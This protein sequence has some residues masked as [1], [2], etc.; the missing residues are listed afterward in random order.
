MS[1]L[2]SSLLLI[3]LL[4]LSG[5]PTPKP[6]QPA[7][8]KPV[9]PAPKPPVRL[10][11]QPASP[12]DYSYAYWLHSWRKNKGEEFP[13][14]LCLETDTY[15]MKLNVD[16]ITKP[17][18]GVIKDK[19]SNLRSALGS[20][21]SRL[22]GLP[23]AELTLEVEHS[24][25][26]YKLESCK[27]A[28]SDASNRLQPVR[29]W[30]AGTI[31][32]HFDIQGLILKNSKGQE[33]RGNNVLD[34]VVWPNSL[35][36]N[37]QIQPA[38]NNEHGVT[39]GVVGSGFAIEKEP[40]VI[41]HSNKPAPKQFTVEMWTKLPEALSDKPYGWLLCNKRHESEDGNF[42]FT[43]HHNHFRASMNIGGGQ[44][45]G[46]RHIKSNGYL[47][48]DK[49]H[50]LVLTYD[51]KTMTFYLDGQA[52][53]TEVINLPRNAGTE[54][55]TLGKRG[56]KAGNLCKALYDQIRMWNRPLNGNEIKS[57]HKN[58]SS[59]APANGLIL[60]HDFGD[61]Y[62]DPVWKNSIIRLGI[63]T[64]ERNWQ[65][66]KVLPDD[67]KVGETQSI[68]LTENFDTPEVE[69]PSLSLS[70]K[71]PKG[72]EIPLVYTPS[73][74]AYSATVL[75]ASQVRSK[76]KG[77]EFRDYDDFN[78]TV[79]NKSAEMVR[80]PVYLDLRGIRAIT[81]LTPILCYEDGTPTGIPV[82]LSKNWHYSKLG[83]Y[84][85]PFFI[86]PS[87]PNSSTQYKLRVVY[88]FYGKLPAASHAQLSL[89][90]YANNTRWDQLAIGCFGET[91]CFDMD[92]ACVPNVVTDVRGLM[93]RD[94]KEGRTWEWTD[95]GWGGDWMRVG[96]GEN[97]E[98]DRLYFNELKTS[99]FAHGPCL[100]DV[101]Y[102]GY[103]GKGHEV[104]MHAQVMTSRTDDYARTFQN[105]SYTFK[106][107]QPA[108]RVTFYAVGG[109]TAVHT[110]TYAYGDKNGIHI[111]AKVPPHVPKGHVLVKNHTIGGEGPWWIGLPD[112]K[113]TRHTDWGNGNR[114]LI[115]RGYEATFS[116]KVYK[117]PTISITVSHDL[118]KGDKGVHIHLT[119]PAGVTQIMPGDKIDMDLQFLTMPRE[120]DDY[121]GP[122][123]H[124]K[125]ILRNHPNS[126]FPLFREVTDNNLAVTVNGGKVLKNYP[127]MIQ[128]ENQNRIEFTIKG[129]R[130]AVPLR[131]EGVDNPLGKNLFRIVNGKEELFAPSVHGNDYR[132]V[133]FDTHS[134]QYHIVYNLP[135]DGVKESQ[136]VFRK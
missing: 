22:N 129:G 4:S 2:I 5:Q 3:S 63:K 61:T 104:E 32:Q 86:L 59:D 36:L 10:K 133:D 107:E 130:G 74:N 65:T 24:G 11:T 99:Y 111:E 106:K 95:C 52:Q 78:I 84:L 93:L 82:Q 110:K 83:A 116:G 41:P 66:Q 89:V 132:Q 135:L 54:L 7:A 98:A 18:F 1:K 94:G 87:D 114:N 88:G 90:G 125:N 126:W 29:M 117:N 123:E 21:A 42:G 8:P 91:I 45:A 127:L 79:E 134:Q 48:R 15:G 77:L 109:R 108:E 76:G 121:Y 80:T 75:H 49:W 53:G 62:K 85:R 51:G 50:H 73:F 38:H 64:P 119:P 55:I 16:E 40:I 57:L 60:N 69:N 19:K 96:I 28:L 34:L 37:A 70:M 97:K 43:V 30:E 56:D 112:S 101:Q 115:I 35:T 13:D 105:L 14:V 31:A 17:H 20:G 124:L 128:T 71:T 46:K 131:I 12:S 136:W 25:Q 81:G 113:V 122:N 47:S 27:A 100:T 68:T 72:E 39:G 58:P 92:T 26:V 67:W 102:D 44:G 23:Q 9:K 120:V 103:L 33:L 6:T 118:G